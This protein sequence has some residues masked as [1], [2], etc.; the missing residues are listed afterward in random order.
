MTTA[1][2]QKHSPSLL[3]W[4]EDRQPFSTVLYSLDEPGEKR[5]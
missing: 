3:A 1:Y 4:S 5:K 2:K